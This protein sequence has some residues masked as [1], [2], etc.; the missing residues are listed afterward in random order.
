MEMESLPY[1]PSILPP[2]DTHPPYHEQP[3]ILPMPHMT[4]NY[5]HHDLNPSVPNLIHNNSAPSTNVVDAGYPPAPH[6]QSLAPQHLHHTQHHEQLSSVPHPPILEPESNLENESRHMEYDPPPESHP[7][8]EAQP[9]LQSQ[10]CSGLNLESEH[11]MDSQPSE[12]ESQEEHPED[13]ESRIEA[14]F[15][16]THEHEEQEERNDELCP[17]SEPEAEIDAEKEEN[18]KREQPECDR[19]EETAEADIE[20]ADVDDQ[21]ADYNSPIPSPAVI[22]PVGEPPPSPDRCSSN[23]D[24]APPMLIA[25]LPTEPLNTSV[26]NFTDEEEPPPPLHMSMNGSPRKIKMPR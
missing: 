7:E 2:H 1:S 20:D 19:Y 15:E 13:Q 22:S 10:S 21:E 17:E 23:S 3:P 9:T 25:E 16:P 14:Y 5:S 12:I 26:F 8:L 18:C 4:S 24:E 11:D 6:L